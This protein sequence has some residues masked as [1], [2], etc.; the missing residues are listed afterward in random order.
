MLLL[1][2]AEKRKSLSIVRAAAWHRTNITL[3]HSRWRFLLAR[4]PL[5]GFF[6]L[7]GSFSSPLSP[8]KQMIIDWTNELDSLDYN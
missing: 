8:T 3:S 2:Q 4:V 6:L 5:V 1:L 7:K